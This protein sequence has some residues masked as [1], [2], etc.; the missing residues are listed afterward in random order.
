M[1]VIKRRLDIC[2]R[3]KTWEY[4]IEAAGEEYRVHARM[5]GREE[6]SFSC[7]CGAGTV[8]A[9]SEPMFFGDPQLRE[10]SH[11]IEAQQDFRIARQAAAQ[12]VP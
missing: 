8:D 5:V 3:E 12:M 1:A 10:C 7:S 11:I 2:G 4:Q 6:P 9:A